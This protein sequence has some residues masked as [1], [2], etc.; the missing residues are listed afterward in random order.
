VLRNG[1]EKTFRTIATNLAGALR[2]ILRRSRQMLGAALPKDEDSDSSDDESK[3][4]SVDASLV[5]I[6]KQGSDQLLDLTCAGHA[7]T[8]VNYG[9]ALIL[10]IDKC[11]ISFIESVLVDTIRNLKAT[12]EDGQ[13]DV[14]VAAPFR[15]D[16]E[17]PNVRE[18]IVWCPTKNAWKLF[19]K[20]PRKPWTQYLTLLFA[21]NL[22]FQHNV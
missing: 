19:V 17:T 1:S 20:K 4:P 3:K 16:T 11:G 6:R 14:E 8:A 13:P 15:F 18:K 10:R 7:F 9:R 2:T 22:F 12:E 21:F 5:A